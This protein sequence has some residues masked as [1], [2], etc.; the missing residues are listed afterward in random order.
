MFSH[1]IRFALAFALV[2]SVANATSMSA[3]ENLRLRPDISFTQDAGS[4][5]P[6]VAEKMDDVAIEPGRPNFIFFG[7]AKNLNTNR[8]AKRLCDL[9]K[10]NAGTTKFIVIDVDNPPNEAAKALMK[11]YYQHYVPAQILLDKNGK[12]VWSQV[13]EV[14]KGRLQSHL[15]AAVM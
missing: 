13:G 3:A 8:Q 1:S 10:K 6:I 9:Y 5:F 4:G 14:Q 15:D 11:Q 12:Q 2:A 7:A